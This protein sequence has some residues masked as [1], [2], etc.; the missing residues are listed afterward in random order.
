MIIIA[1]RQLLAKSISSSTITVKISSNSIII[2]TRGDPIMSTDTMNITEG[3]GECELD[4]LL[5][6]R[7]S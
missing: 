4:F 1:I 3:I 2:I 5:G 7:S 6:N